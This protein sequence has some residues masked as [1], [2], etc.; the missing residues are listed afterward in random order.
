MS[1]SHGIPFHSELATDTDTTGGLSDNIELPRNSHNQLDG[2]NMEAGTYPDPLRGVPD[3]ILFR[4]LYSRGLFCPPTLPSNGSAQHPHG[5]QSSRAG[6]SFSLHRLS[7][8]SSLRSCS[9]SAATS[10]RSVAAP[11]SRSLLMHSMASHIDGGEILQWP[12]GTICS[13]NAHLS[14]NIPQHSR[15]GDTGRGIEPPQDPNTRNSEDSVTGKQFFC[16][17]CYELDIARNFHE[18]GEE[19]H[20]RAQSCAD[21]FSRE[22]D[23]KKHCDKQ[24]PEKGYPHEKISVPENRA[25][26]CGFKGCRKITY[27]WKDRCNHVARCM[28]EGGEWSYSWKMRNLLRQDVVSG[29]WKKVRSNWGQR[30]DIDPSAL[31][32]H[33][34]TSR[35]LRQQLECNSFGL[36]LENL[37]ERL[38]KLGHPH[39]NVHCSD[40]FP[41]PS[42][43]S[44]SDYPSSG[45]GTLDPVAFEQDNSFIAAPSFFD[46]PPVSSSF[47][48]IDFNLDAES[49]NPSEKRYSV[50]MTDVEPPAAT[51]TDPSLPALDHAPS[52]LM[53]WQE[54]ALSNTTPPLPETCPEGTGEVAQDG[55]KTSPRRN[56]VRKSK[57]WLTCKKSQ[58]LQQPIVTNHPDLALNY[59]H[60]TPAR[61]PPSMSPTGFNGNSMFNY[62]A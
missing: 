52:D 40:G 17:F 15:L 57:S 44:A 28:L 45:T 19:W 16:T 23:F 26:A 30:L 41:V 20:C 8:G 27:N 50:A 14:N 11:Q 25:Y 12:D 36:D 54:F 24:H 22:S 55:Q 51:N 35:N 56:L 39:Y 46:Q 61:K 42:S 47:E 6:S 38:F 10:L 1:T 29:T 32:W 31:E 48:D 49:V 53:T 37:L 33:P 3:D 4:S 13:E 34:K 58:Q 60:P 21:V 59:R 7:N 18:T 62:P 9:S 43:R 5:V 2:E